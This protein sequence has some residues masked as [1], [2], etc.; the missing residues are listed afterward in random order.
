MHLTTDPGSFHY[1]SHTEDSLQ[2]ANSS[3]LLDTPS[4]NN[5]QDQN[6]FLN[7][8]MDDTGS[9]RP[10]FHLDQVN[11]SFSH[12]VQ[13]P[14]NHTLQPP[15]NHTIQPPANHTIQSPANHTIQPP[16]NHTIQPPAHHTI[17]PPANHT[18]QPPANHTLQP[19]NHTLQPSANHTIQPPSNH[20]LQP[21]ANHTIQISNSPKHPMYVDVQERINS[22]LC[23][24]THHCH[25]PVN[26]AEAGFFY[27]DVADCVTCFYCG[28]ALRYLQPHDDIVDK[29]H[30]YRPQCQYVLQILQKLRKKLLKRIRMKPSDGNRNSHTFEIYFL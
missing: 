6:P 2:S 10:S 8:Q 28:L 30:Q 22:F 15:A 4:P 26:L 23:W 1:P 9:Q 17:Q 19:A 14:A 11:P 21:P 18:L 27:Q 24:P 29:H 7:Q 16:A 12:I 5:A 20:T 13:P 25:N 3:H